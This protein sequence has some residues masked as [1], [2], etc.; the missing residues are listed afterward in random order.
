MF[1]TFHRIIA[2]VY[3]HHKDLFNKYENKCRL[4]ERQILFCTKKKKVLGRITDSSSGLG[5]LV[6]GFGATLFADFG[7]T[8]V[9]T[10]IQKN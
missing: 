1:K 9:D 7:L 2:H 5:V 8:A 6:A 10:F 3:H 4:N